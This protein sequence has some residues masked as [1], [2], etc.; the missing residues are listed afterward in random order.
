MQKSVL[1][2]KPA[3]LGA[4]PEATFSIV[5]ALSFAHL[6]NDMMQSL[7]PA[8]YPLI[9]DAY[10]LD[11]GQIGLITLAFQLTAS[12]LQPVV[13][14]YTD[15]RPQPYSLVAGMGCTLVGLIVL[16]HAGSY[17]LLLIGAALIGT[18][19]SIFHPESTRM[20][21]MASGGRH[22]F[23]QS[24][25][26]VGGQAGQSLGPLLAAFIVV[27]RGQASI[28]WFS[29]VALLAMVL[30]LQVGQWYKRQSPA[31]VKARNA[32]GAAGT[33]SPAANV[34]LALVILVVLMFS[35]NAYTASLSTYYTFYL[36]G[37]FSVSVQ[38]SQMLLFLFLV[39]QA[40]GSLIGGHLG[41]R[42]GRREIIWFSI[43]GAVPFTLL[44]PFANLFWTAVLTIV[45][46]MIMASAF[47][48]ILVYALELL[49]GKVGM[50][51]G[52][53]YGVS[54]GL[55]ALSAAL[56]GELAD[57]TSIEFVYRMCAFL[58]LLG[59]LTW[60]L[61]KIERPRMR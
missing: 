6:L 12:L 55:G 19:S 35:K 49:P 59:L 3:G 51:A 15:R 46:G 41:D 9:K 20:A 34:T 18:G 61:P 7:L 22:G 21:R 24:L 25:F 44:L 8:I 37:K 54:F 60:F 1:P 26:Q 13:G 29:L 38:Y 32:G 4:A 33:Q 53:F 52:L 56:M 36:I 48:A 57:H 30:L 5:L 42:F 28:S 47:P 2:E 14:M 16:A 58:P 11:F 43:V 39:A 23:A 10:G 31:P 45:I 17:A 40:L 50:I 27:P